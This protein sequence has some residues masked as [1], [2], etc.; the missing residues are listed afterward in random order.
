M[1]TRWKLGN[2]K[3]VRLATELPFSSLTI[4]AGANS[5]GK[6]SWIQSILLVSQ[7]LAH[8][9]GTR[10]V[11]LNGILARLGQFDD[12]RSF[13][14]ED[15]HIEIG[16]E[17]R[18][19]TTAST[20]HKSSVPYTAVPLRIDPRSTYLPLS[21]SELVSI[22]CE[23]SFAAEPSLTG[24]QTELTQLHPNL[25]NVSLNCTARNEEILKQPHRSP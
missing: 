1:I 13:G 18:P 12:L 8:R 11:V 24:R 2:F 5:S 19:L 6:S 3:S 9:V 10:S 22:S 7:T 15:K 21:A 25:L 23:L 20:R 16:W 14:S 17:C 4:F